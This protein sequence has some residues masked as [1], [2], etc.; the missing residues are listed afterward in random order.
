MVQIVPVKVRIVPQVNVNRPSRVIP[1]R[2]DEVV[3][4]LPVLTHATAVLGVGEDGVPVVWD[5]LGGKSL[6]ILGEGL[7]LPWQV[8]DAARVSLEQHNTRHLVEITWVTEREA[9]GHRITDVVCPHDRA[10]EQAL[11]RLADLVDR[12]RHGQNRGATQVLILDDLAQVL[13]ADV[14]AHW[15]LE[16]VLK[17]GGKNGVQVLAGADYRALTR[18]PVKG[19]DGRF[20][21]VLRQVGDRFSTP[22]GTVIPVEV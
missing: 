22:T 10:L 13:K 4:R 6:L 16:F 9:R 12:R 7:A 20:G 2:L 8:L 17:H 15:A 1:R 18:R 19:W 11:Y 3:M 5:A 14:E 21:S